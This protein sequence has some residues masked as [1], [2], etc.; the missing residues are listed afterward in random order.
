MRFDRAKI[1][2]QLIATLKADS[3]LDAANV[4]VRTH[5]GDVNPAVF[6]DPSMKTQLE[7]FIRQLPFVY[8]QYQGKR[9]VSTDS[10]KKTAYY[11]LRWRFYVGTKSLREKRDAQLSAYDIL[12]S[13]Y[14]AIH[15]RIP[16]STDNAGWVIDKLSG[17]PILTPI[18]VTKPF[19]SA[20]GEDEKLLVNIPGVVVYS[21]DFVCQVQ[22]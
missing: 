15:G 20:E 17:D 9:K 8:V 11:N 16:N 4:N 3:V 1:E 18:T 13:L 2:D 7:G 21:S 14:D 5:V 6:L 19:E 10:T 22:A 12:D